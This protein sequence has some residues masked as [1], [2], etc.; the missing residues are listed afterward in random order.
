MID[1]VIDRILIESELSIDPIEH[2]K[3]SLENG[4]DWASALLEAMSLWAIPE[5][6][7]GGRNYRYFI[8]GEAFDW[9]VLAERLCS[10]VGD[11]IPPQDKDDLLFTGRLP[12]YIDGGYFKDLLGVQKYRGFLNFFYGVTIEEALQLAVE[13]EVQK[14]HISNGNLY[15][16]DFSP[17]AFAKIYHQ[18]KDVLLDL[19]RLERGY[20]DVDSM[21][22]DESKEFT[23]WLFKYRMRYTD[24]AKIAS[25]TRKGIEQLRQMTDGK[26]YAL[27]L[28]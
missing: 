5:E 24:Q 14:R 12:D 21:S 22:L 11:L 7:Y 2:L 19:F 26:S 28:V 6:S 23:Y 3:S 20:P 8:G 16:D 27:T 4:R 25:D 9:L 18:S 1:E 10:E 13:R 17:E 15:Q